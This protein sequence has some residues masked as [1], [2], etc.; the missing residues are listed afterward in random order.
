MAEDRPSSQLTPKQVMTDAR[1]D[2]SSYLQRHLTSASVVVSKLHPIMG[3][4]VAAMFIDLTHKGLASDTP[5][6]GDFQ[7]L[8]GVRTKAHQI[9]LY[10]DICLRQRRCAYVANPYRVHGV[11]AEG[12]Q[13]QGSNHQAQRQSWGAEAIPAGNEVGYAID[14]R[15]NRG[16]NDAAWKPVHDICRTYGLD[17]P[18]KSGAVER[19]HFEWFPRSRSA[20]LGGDVAWPK[21]PGI[22]RP[23]KKGHIGGDVRKLQRQ[24]GVKVVDGVFGVGTENGVKELEKELGL[25]ANGVWTAGNQR[26]WEK[27]Q[28]QSWGAPE[29]EPAPAPEP[30]P[31]PPIV[32]PPEAAATAML[33]A[34]LVQLEEARDAMDAAENSIDH[35]VNLL[36]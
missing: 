9:A 34:A 29:P 10:N 15:N 4:R 18:L 20:P 16:S 7:I 27:A 22:H 14:I 6:R 31:A 13:R 26:K 36:A 30:E 35:A 28:R 25:T 23:L 3:L 1:F 5:G 8:S 33:N 19:W 21:R 32:I 11:D 12:V 24:L 17:W 2:W